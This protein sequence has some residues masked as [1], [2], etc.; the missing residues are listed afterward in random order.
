D[1]LYVVAKTKEVSGGNTRYVQRLHALDITTGAEKFG[2]PVVIDATVDGTGEGSV[3]GRVPF[4]SLRQFQRAALLLSQGVVYIAFGSHGDARP[5]HGWLFGYDARTLQREMVFMTS[6]NAFGGGIWQAG[7]G[8]AA[9]AAGNIYFATGNGTFSV[10]Q[11][12]FD[13]GDSYVR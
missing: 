5:W 2:G 7:G 11:G 6:P 3:G 12:G 13:W 10:N 9:D 4:D 1:T 8:P